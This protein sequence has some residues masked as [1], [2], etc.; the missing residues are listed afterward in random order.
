MPQFHVSYFKAR[1]WWLIA[2]CLILLLT[3]EWNVESSELVTVILSTITVVKLFFIWTRQNVT[4]TTTRSVPPKAVP[5]HVRPVTS[6][7]GRVEIS[8]PAAATPMMTLVPHPLWQASRAALCRQETGQCH[9]DLIQT[10]PDH[11]CNLVLVFFRN[12]GLLMPGLEWS[13]LSEGVRRV[14]H[15]CKTHF[16]LLIFLWMYL[17]IYMLFLD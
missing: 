5:F 7:K 14:F 6:W 12:N 4:L 17:N 9:I 15:H 3:T 13:G 16:K 10:P 8:C 1:W 2:K 11:Y